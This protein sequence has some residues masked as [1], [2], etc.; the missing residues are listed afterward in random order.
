MKFLPTSLL[1]CLAVLIS[2]I[3][4]IVGIS[5]LLIHLLDLSVTAGWIAVGSLSLLSVAA[6]LVLRHE[7]LHAIELPDDVDLDYVAPDTGSSYGERPSHAPVLPVDAA[8]A[9]RVPSQYY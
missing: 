2:C 8:P 3:A 9:F 4:W 7:V 6:L 5:W 1:T